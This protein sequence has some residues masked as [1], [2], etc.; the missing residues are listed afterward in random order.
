MQNAVNHACGSNDEQKYKI[1]AVSV[2]TAAQVWHHILDHTNM[3]LINVMM[4]GRVYGMLPSEVTQTQSFCDV[5]RRKTRKVV[6][7]WTCL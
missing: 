6:V 3:S 1:R 4:T 5:P 7:K 2:G